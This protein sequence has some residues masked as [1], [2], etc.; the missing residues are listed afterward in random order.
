MSRPW[1]SAPKRRI[2]STSSCDTPTPPSPRMR[3]PPPGR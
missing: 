3:A 2:T 1:M